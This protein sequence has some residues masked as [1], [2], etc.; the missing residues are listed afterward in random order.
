MGTIRGSLFNFL[1]PIFTV[2]DNG[3]LLRHAAFAADWAEKW[4]EFR[5]NTQEPQTKERGSVS[6][7][8]WDQMVLTRESWRSSNM[9]LQKCGPKRAMCPC[10]HPAMLAL[11]LPAAE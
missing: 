5:V 6:I 11:C 10:Q 2:E 8:H 3:E 1:A 9:K 4:E 7:T